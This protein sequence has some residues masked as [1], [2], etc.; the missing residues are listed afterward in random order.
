MNKSRRL[1]I[2][3]KKAIRRDS[4][5]A[6]SRTT[7]V[8]LGTVETFDPTDVIIRKIRPRRRDRDVVPIPD[9]DYAKTFAYDGDFP[10]AIDN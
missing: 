5:S 9:R 8:N 4:Q 2:D 1:Q 10:R 3:R 7:T 6:P